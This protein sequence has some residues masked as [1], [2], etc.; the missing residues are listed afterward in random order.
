MDTLGIVSTANVPDLAKTFTLRDQ[1]QTHTK[2]PR[3]FISA[4]AINL[5]GPYFLTQLLL[6]TFVERRSGCVINIAS[7]SGSIDSPFNTGYSV[8][9]AALI[10]LTGCLQKELDALGYNDIHIYAI[11]PGAVRSALASSG[12][13]IPITNSVSIR[14]FSNIASRRRKTRL[15]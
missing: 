10:R 6:S 15:S 1:L 2:D 4:L 5:N 12:M 13:V 8:S 11:H 3:H 9:K 14:P 7:R